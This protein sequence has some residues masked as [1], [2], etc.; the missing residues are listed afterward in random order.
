MEEFCGENKKESF[1]L[2]YKSKIFKLAVIIAVV[3][4]FTLGCFFLFKSL[5]LLDGGTASSKLSQGGFW[6]YLIFIALFVVQAVCLCMVPGNTT[7]FIGIAWLVFDNFWIVLF[8]C[9]L[10][11]W[12]S[13]I[14]LF[15]V[16]RF[17]GRHVIYWLFGKEQVDKKLDWV[18]QKGSNAL[19][20]FFLIPF[21]PNDMVCMVCGMSRLRFWQFLLIIIPFRLIE[22]L[23]ILSYPYIIDFFI[24]GRP[25][26]DVLIFVNVILIDIV[27]V[28]LYYRTIIK[29]FHRTILRKKAV[30]TPRA[31]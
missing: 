1:F 23:M 7:T 22:V 8:I 29:I 16:G 26:Q 31:G 9:V 10:G 4:V 28:A 6:V 27:L 3:A 17:G 30:K 20:A 11:V 5:G 25:V 18:T 19:P 14:A 15:F 24:S 12:L 2:K 21:M 13:G